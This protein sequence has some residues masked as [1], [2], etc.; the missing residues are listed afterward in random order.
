MVFRRSHLGKLNIITISLVLVLCS[1]TDSVF[2]DASLPESQE[3]IHVCHIPNGKASYCVTRKRC[4]PLDDLFNNVTNLGD[5]SVTKY[6]NNSFV[7]S[8]ESST[9]SHK[10]CCP[11]ENISNPKEGKRPNTTSIGKHYLV[12]F[13]CI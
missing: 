8:N 6:L 11:F 2:E 13:L 9:R 7:C 3:K 10:V 1:L 12:L 4:K 5:K